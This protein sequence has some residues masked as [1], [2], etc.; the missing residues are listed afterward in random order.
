MR[1]FL[2]G[3]DLDSE[4]I[5]TIMAEHGKLVTKDKEELQT[6]KSQ[7]KDLKENS[8]NADELQSKYDELVKANEER[9][10]K[11]KAEE[12]DD[13]LTKNINSVFGDKKFVNDFTKN[14][15][16]NE[17]K[18]ALKDSA[19]MG[20]SAKDLFEEITNGKDGIFEN[21]NKVVDMPSVDETVEN[22]VSKADFDKMG[23]KERLELK[24][25]NPELFNK[26]NN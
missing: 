13:I 2:K 17:I 16:M 26:Y 4:L 6:L 5:D 12:E 25:S 10:A 11:K 24:A 20:K 23:Y 9:E 8:K 18:T 14:A 15:I 19:N 21:P 1:E 7:L 3:L 22:V